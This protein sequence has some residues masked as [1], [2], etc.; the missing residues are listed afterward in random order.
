[1]A[2]VADCFTFNARRAPV[3]CLT[4]KLRGGYGRPVRFTHRG[5]RRR[6]RACARGLFGRVHGE[7]KVTARKLLHGS[8]PPTLDTRALV[9]EVHRTL[10]HQEG[11]ALQQRV[12]FFAL[13]AS[14]MRQIVMDRA[15]AGL[16]GKRTRDEIDFIDID[17]AFDISDDKL[18]PEERLVMGC[19]LAD[20]ERKEPALTELVELRYLAGL[21]LP[22]VAL[23][24]EVGDRTSGRDWRRAKA[25]L[26][27]RLHP[28][29]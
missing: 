25:R 5:R 6:K 16:R 4:G 17:A 28:D 9:H 23:R 12:R 18:S 13:A 11:R 1:M 2:A 29:A 10:S 15:H 20:L 19:A 3:Y 26:Y 21:P 27:V 8:N 14:A 7:L 24:R 22:D